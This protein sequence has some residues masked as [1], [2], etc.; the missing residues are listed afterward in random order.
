MWISSGVGAVEKLVE[1]GHELLG[2]GRVQKV[3]G[4]QCLFQVLQHTREGLR[5][6]GGPLRG[7]GGQVK[8]SERLAPVVSNQLHRGR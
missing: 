2:R 6:G 4:D 5:I 3:D 7:D 1:P 8:S